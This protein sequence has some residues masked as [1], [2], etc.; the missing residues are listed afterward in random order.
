MSTMRILFIV[1]SVSLHVQAAIGQNAEKIETDR[2]G[3]AQTPF[4]VP[5]RTLQAETGFE[6]E[7]QDENQQEIQHPEIVIKYGLLKA[8]E[9][10]TRILSVTDKFKQPS[11]SQSG[12]QPVEFGLKALIT[13]GKGIIPHTS[14]TA[15]FGIPGFASKDYKAD[16]LFPKI[17]LNLENDLT[18]KIYMEYNVAA[19]WDGFDDKP[20]WMV[21]VSPHAEIGEKW[22]IFAEA[23]SNMQQQKEPEVSVD[24]GLTYWITNDVMLDL[25][26]G[27]GISKAAPKSFADIGFSF[28][29]K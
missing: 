15:Q 12:L 28:R 19:E 8:L 5:R 17:R 21:I 3:K 20:V 27:V 16:K 23:F 26:G 22:Q 10:R 24:A 18:H 2:P 13:E 25:A 11:H 14:L 29:L 9:L 6:I 4:V 1:V 7:K